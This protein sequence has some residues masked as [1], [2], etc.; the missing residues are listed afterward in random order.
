MTLYHVWDAI[1]ESRDNPDQIE[2]VDEQ[3]AAIKYAEED[4]DG[5][6]DGV[7]NGGHPIAVD[8]GTEVLCFQVEV[9]YDPVYWAK[10]IELPSQ[11]PPRE[12]NFVKLEG[13]DD[14]DILCSVCGLDPWDYHHAPYPPCKDPNG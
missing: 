4:V 3:Q 5:N 10:R 1:N 12:H 13:G 9:E 7:Y 11:E 8:N 2:A 6:T 14:Y